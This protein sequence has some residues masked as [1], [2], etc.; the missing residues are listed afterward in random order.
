M[1]S[2][3]PAGSKSDC[4]ITHKEIDNVLAVKSL[5]VSLTNHL[6]FPDLMVEPKSFPLSSILYNL[7]LCMSKL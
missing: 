5:S 1:L 3:D 6:N 7:K 4:E 2:D